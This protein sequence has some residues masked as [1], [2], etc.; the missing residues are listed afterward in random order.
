MVRSAV[1]TWMLWLLALVIT[2]SAA[3]YQR[4]TG[5]TWPLRG[6]VSVGGA[7]ITY[8][9]NRSHAG[10]GDEE[11]RLR[12]PEQVIAGALFLRRFPSN[13]PW[14]TVEMEREG[15]YL[16]SRIPHQPPAGKVMY[17]IELSGKDGTRTPLTKDPVQ[18]RFRGEVPAL[19]IIPHI[20]LMFAAMLFSNRAGLA[21]LLSGE[22]AYRESALLRPM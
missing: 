15:E 3:L 4:V 1:K 22:R 20:I 12:V 7:Q 6:E 13:D 5:P 19:V 21:V 14:S 16:V 10:Q 2:L 9:L 11:I 18:I 17:R 8:K